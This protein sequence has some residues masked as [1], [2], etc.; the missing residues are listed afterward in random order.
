MT[1]I[2][3][4]INIIPA[5]VV[6]AV[7]GH[8]QL[9]DHGEDALRQGF[10]LFHTREGE[11]TVADAPPVFI[12]NFDGLEG[13]AVDHGPGLLQ[14]VFGNRETIAFELPEG[15]E[16]LQILQ[17]DEFHIDFVF[18][19]EGFEGREIREPVHPLQAESSDV[20]VC[21]IRDRE[22]APEPELREGSAIEG[23]PVGEARAA[24]DFQRLQG[25]GGDEILQTMEA[26][27]IINRVEAEGLCLH[28]AED[29]EIRRI[30]AAALGF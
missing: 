27:E 24:E 21:Q 15:A 11:L 6:D 10:E 8:I 28:G 9:R 20:H 7:A 5:A 14:E 29:G 12:R 23:G 30:L 17:V 4:V 18:L 1:V 16:I 22:G 13:A 3:V 25:T 26:G 19:R 2:P